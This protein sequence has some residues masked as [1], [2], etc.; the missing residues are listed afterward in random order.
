MM[1]DTDH[2]QIERL[3]RRL[4]EG[5]PHTVR[6]SSLWL[7]VDVPAFDLPDHG[8]KLH[9]SSR[10]SGYAEFAEFVVPALLDLGCPFKLART[11]VLL[12]A[13]NDGL[14]NP[15]AV[16]KA[17]TVYPPQD[18]VREI[19]LSLA[20]L[21]RGRKGPRVVSDRRVADDAPVYYRYGPFIA[22]WHANAGGQVATRLY[23]PAGE[24]FDGEASLTYRQP[25]WAEDPFTGGAAGPT[26]QAVIGGRYRITAGVYES[27]RG[28]VFRAIDERNGS[29]VV[30]KQARAYVLESEDGLDTR[31]RLRNER[32]VLSMLGDVEGVPRFLDH[33]R[34]GDDEFLVIT[35][36]GERNLEQDLLAAG[37]YPLAAEDPPPGR[38]L[39]D[40]AC[41]LA[42]TLSQVHERGVVMYDL[43]PKNVVTGA[44][45][46]LVDFGFAAAGGLHMKGGT[47]G[48]MPERQRRRMEPL[49]HDD[50][51]GLG[52][53]LWYAAGFQQPVESDDD[54]DLPRR[55]ALQQIHRAF[56]PAPQGVI[57]AIAEL[58]SGDPD[59]A[60]AAARALAH[61]G[62][63]TFRVLYR[64]SSGSSGSSGM[65]GFS[66]AE[67]GGDG[68]GGP[69]ETEGVPELPAPPHVDRA[70]IADL[71]RSVRADL[72]AQ[73]ATVVDGHSDSS[74]EHDASLYSG[75]A[76]VAAELLRHRDDPD[77]AALLPRLLEHARTTA[78]RT[79]LP[80]GLYAGRTGVD[81]VL[82]EAGVC[83]NPP[84]PGA[85]WTP[86]G[87]DVIIGAAGVGL[88]HLILH[89]RGLGDDH[90]RVAERCVELIA[91]GTAPSPYTSERYP[92][93][94]GFETAVGY[95]HGLAGEIDFLLEYAERTGEDRAAELAA[96]KLRELA[97]RTEPL[98]AKAAG[99]AAMPLAISWC[100]GHAGV[101]RVL[102]RAGTV[103]GEPR[104]TELAVRC[105]EVCL[106]WL[107]RLV[108]VGP[109]CGVSGVGHLLV[110]LAVATGERRY[111]DAARDAVTQ[112]LLRSGGTHDRP[113]FVT[114]LPGE[115]GPSWAQG[116]TGVLT[117]LRRLRDDG[118]PVL[119]S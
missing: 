112:L 79:A 70:L 41:S 9:L 17:C 16:G 99:R 74:A 31:L 3:V 49:D 8:W 80:H 94:A 63:A 56:G 29:T 82:Q 77:V 62:G 90:L 10:E 95:A 65:S 13:L 15:A 40:L 48:Y 60:R 46:F 59:R 69:A 81:L 98:L 92:E 32:R 22:S 85:D 37:R 76:G 100:Q 105:A 109:C 87:P 67:G 18:R 96:V 36:A 118:G 30:V 106:G 117:F 21:L 86:E 113:V 102:L 35:D 58:L 50:W 97:G 89:G 34:H 43:A 23:G 72:V 39:E 24:V 71:V 119:L 68:A 2:E 84:V 26:G 78:A 73:T 110:D 27:A 51:H 42:R 38:A 12:G 11:P 91:T 101:G 1:T 75:S 20:G 108:V 107:P 111:R 61:D 114:G 55:R 25:P 4:A 44:R 93:T 57:G 116:L 88:G 103:L 28:S 52:M 83:P 19:G 54:F 66:G 115:G 5:R 7:M 47:F 33:F 14:R 64:R 6:R 104:H 45:P 53:T